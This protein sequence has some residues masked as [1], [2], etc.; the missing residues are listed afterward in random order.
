MDWKRILH[1]LRQRKMARSIWI[2][3]LSLDFDRESKPQSA[4][5]PGSSMSVLKIPIRSE[6][7]SLLKQSSKLL[8][9]RTQKSLMQ[10]IVSVKKPTDL[11]RTSKTLNRQSRSIA[12]LMDQFHPKTLWFVSLRPTAHST[13]P[14][15]H[16]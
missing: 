12:K 15:R 5:E 10:I 14:L 8:S 16:G 2:A 9:I 11:R 3:N 6:Q 1:S 4:V 7:H 13:N